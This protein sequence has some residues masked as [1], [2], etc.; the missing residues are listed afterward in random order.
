MTQSLGESMYRQFMSLA[1]GLTA[2]ACSEVGPTNPFDPQAPKSVQALGTISGRVANLEDGAPVNGARVLLY[3]SD[4]LPEQVCAPPMGPPR[5]GGPA[6]A[7][8]GVSAPGERPLAEATSNERGVFQLN[9]LGQGEYTLCVNHPR[10]LPLR[11]GELVVPIGGEIALGEDLLLTPGKGTVIAQVDLG[12]LE[13][14]SDRGQTVIQGVDVTLTPIG[15]GLGNSSNGTPDAQGT[16]TFSR[17]PLGSWRLRFAHPDYRPVVEDI[18]LETIGQV[19]EVRGLL[20]IELE[21]NPGTVSGVLIL[22]EPSPTSMEGIELTLTDENEL[23]TEVS[24]TLVT[25]PEQADYGRFTI[26]GAA[27]RAGFYRLNI[28]HTGAEYQA[29]TIAPVQVRAGEGTDLGRIEVSYARGS[30][31]GTIG[32]AD[33]ASTAGATVTLSGLTEAITQ[34]DG[35]GAYRFDN[36]RGGTYQLGVTLSG[37][38]PAR[39]EG[40]VVRQDEETVVDNVVLEVD[41]GSLTGRVIDES[42]N[43]IE[44]VSAGIEGSPAETADGTLRSPDSERASTPSRSAR[45]ATSPRPFLTKR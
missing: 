19:I 37:Y 24:I 30:I 45:R 36:V 4:R 20:P 33:N 42:G 21:V 5:M 18:E 14:G 38:R 17:I 41:P 10:F 12:D 7:D 22:E 35:T 28:V 16:V 34:T 13:V 43:P 31:R 1:V 27:L 23:A 44:G 15:E 6:N 25:D 3:R 32:T 2:L 26:D 40:E 9:D 29:R 8:G 11:R 39:V